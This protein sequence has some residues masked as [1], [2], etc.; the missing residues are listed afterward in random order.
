MINFLDN[1]KKIE[2][3]IQTFKP[4]ILVLCIDFDGTLTKIYESPF[5]AVLEDNYRGIIENIR[6]IENIFFCIV[7]G[8]ELSD[9]IKRID[10][11]SN[12]I[13]SGNHGFEIK[14]LY[15]KIKLNFVY[16]DL[17]NYMFV[18]KDIIKKVNEI[19]IKNLII[20]NKKYSI[21]LHYRIL[22]HENIKILKDEVKHIMNSNND[23]KSMFE[24][25]KGK[26]IIE[27]RP[28]IKWDKGKACDFIIKKISMQLNG[29]FHS[30]LNKDNSNYN[31]KD[32]INM[33][34]VNIG[35]DLTDETMF[36]KNKYSFKSNSKK[37]NVMSINCVVGEKESS[38]DYYI[39]NHRQTYEVLENISNVFNNSKF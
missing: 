34:R 26:K 9:I 38:A 37:I 31:K 33:L 19:P 10:I 21:S 28:K 18:L 4:D 36:Y 14:S 22:R 1:L 8:R 24:L 11:K 15:E 20:E 12:I 2:N 29:N 32:I 30:G 7:T 6:I 3:K 13:Y 5:D 17:K 39:N 25:K 27:I 23:F 16:K 35:D